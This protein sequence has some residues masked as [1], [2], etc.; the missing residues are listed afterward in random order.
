MTITIIVG[1]IGSIIS[2]ITGTLWYSDKTPMGKVHMRYLGFDKLSQ[3]EKDALKQ[4][5][6]PNMWKTYSLQMLLSLL[7]SLFIGFVTSYTVA[8]GGPAS[9][10]YFYIVLIWIAFTVPMIGQN[11]LWGNAGR[12]LAWKKF[13]SDTLYNLITFL[14]IAFVATLFV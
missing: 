2:A 9:A 8:N 3:A 13:F 11:L 6:M 1:V 10:V 5:A 14:I 12:S 7:T 4:K